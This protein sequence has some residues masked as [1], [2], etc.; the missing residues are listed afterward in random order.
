MPVAVV[1]ADRDRLHVRPSASTTGCSSEPWNLS[2]RRRRRSS[3]PR[4]RRRSRRPSAARRAARSLMRAVSRAAR[5]LDEERAASRGS[6]GRSPASRAIS[7]LGDEARGLHG[8]QH[9]DVEP[10]DVVRDDQHGCRCG[11]SIAPCTRASTFIS[12]QQLAGTSAASARAG[13]RPSARGNTKVSVA[14]PREHVHG[15][16]RHAPA[17][18]GSATVVRRVRRGASPASA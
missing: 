14:M 3:C 13:A 17:R 7:R 12:S 10:R 11:A 4:G 1:V 15:H 8:L 6:A 9:E 5:A 18:I 2:T 16:A